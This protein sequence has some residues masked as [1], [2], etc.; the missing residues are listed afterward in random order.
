MSESTYDRR[1][2]SEAKVKGRG[3]LG[4]SIKSFFTYM[5]GSKKEEGPSHER[6]TQSRAG[7]LRAAILSHKMEGGRGQTLAEGQQDDLYN[8]MGLSKA[9]LGDDEGEEKKKA[10]FFK[11]IAF[12][13]GAK[14][15]ET[16]ND[17]DFK[18]TVYMKAPKSSIGKDD[19]FSIHAKD[20]YLKFA[21]INKPRKVPGLNFSIGYD[22]DKDRKVTDFQHSGTII[23]PLYDDEAPLTA[24]SLSFDDDAE[25]L[26]LRD[27][28]MTSRFKRGSVS[29]KDHLHVNQMTFGL[30]ANG[31]EVEQEEFDGAL[32]DM[33]L[34]ADNGY[35]DKGAHKLPKRLA[36]KFKFNKNQP[37]RF[38]T[39][40]FE[41]NFNFKA[42]GDVDTKK[43]KDAERTTLVLKQEEGVSE[44]GEPQKMQS[45][46]NAV[47]DISH[48]IF[49]KYFS[50]KRLT[51]LD[52]GHQNV[53]LFKIN[54]MVN[55]CFSGAFSDGSLTAKRESSGAMTYSLSAEEMTYENLGL[56]VKMKDIEATDDGII[57][58]DIEAEHTEAKIANI[59]QVTLSK[60]L[61]WDIEL[62]NIAIALGKEDQDIGALIPESV[63]NFEELPFKLSLL[64]DFYFG[65]ASIKMK[66]I[67]QLASDPKVR[68]RSIAFGLSDYFKMKY[69]ILNKTVSGSAEYSF[70]EEEEKEDLATISVGIPIVPGVEAGMEFN[71]GFG[72]ELSGSVSAKRASAQWKFKDAAI[73]ADAELSA[74]L[75]AFV[76]AGNSNIV[77][78]A[79]KAYADFIAKMSAEM[80]LEG[81]LIRSEASSGPDSE[82]ADGTTFTS[83]FETLIATK[84]G[85][86]LE[87][88]AL[89]IFRKTLYKIE[90]KEYELGSFALSARK[91]KGK[92]WEFNYDKEMTA[93]GG[94]L[95]TV[96]GEY[97]D[98]RDFYAELLSLGEDS[99]IEFVNDEE[100]NDVFLRIKG[101]S[102]EVETLYNDR[103]DTLR[104]RFEGHRGNL[105]RIVASKGV[106]K[107]RYRLMYYQGLERGYGVERT[108]GTKDESKILEK[109]GSPQKLCKLLKNKTAKA[110]DLDLKPDEPDIVRILENSTYL[111]DLLDHEHARLNHYA[112]KI[113]KGV[114]VADL[115]SSIMYI[116]EQM[117][118]S[119]NVLD[120][121]QSFNPDEGATINLSR[122]AKEYSYSEGMIRALVKDENYHSKIKSE[123]SDIASESVDEARKLQLLEEA[124]NREEEED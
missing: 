121:I 116:A 45:A 66:D 4:S 3:G 38:S 124:M 81:G 50:F 87:A 36:L 107:H 33:A 111:T 69:D 12:Y 71:L 18:K 52:G 55:S 64:S 39:A 80:N 14:K 94:F 97:S 60:D 93:T 15:D 112:G 120:A 103:I 43:S 67:R 92:D 29:G 89:R 86:K 74:A 49:P 5:S 117:T 48:T 70:P 53:F 101:K 118:I 10:G 99:Q 85:A 113:V 82:V 68:V 57:A 56:T 20:I 8:L 58:H 30:T 40:T 16:L 83:A 102:E 109:L 88:R 79:L 76:A 91:I 122:T 35:L 26:I 114:D 106:Q 108:F 34:D 46:L 95:G 42:T 59:D 61:N 51:A 44:T 23:M 77:A 119:E 115:E 9:K 31:I 75:G 27:I 105:E 1:E 7:G 96:E 73:N 47:H 21:A 11:K 17:M 28:N 65:F 22:A 41:T 25:Q 37:F 32:V 90:S 123:H 84:F 62:Q 2:S 19:H 104:I 98:Q 6:T 100:S 63:I 72:F 13:F 24:K 54:G 110:V 78:I